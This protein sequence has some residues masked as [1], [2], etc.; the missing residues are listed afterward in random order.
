MGRQEKPISGAVPAVVVLAEFLREQRRQAGG[1][2]YS[3]LAEFSTYDKTTLSR[4]ASGRTTPGE[5]IVLD[6]VRACAAAQGHSPDEALAQARRLWR[7]ARYEER[8]AAD[9]SQ[10][11]P[12][13]EV[14]LIA[15]RAEMSAALRELYEKAGAPS[16]QRM[17]ELAGGYGRLPHSTAHRIV[18]RG[19]LP[20]SVRQLTGFLDAC[21]V[22]GAEQRPWIDAW[23]KAHKDDSTAAA[24]QQLH[25]ARAAEMIVVPGRLPGSVRQL[26]V[27]L[28]ACGVAGAE[29]RPWID[30]WRKA[31]QDSAA[32]APRLP[33]STDAAELYGTT[34]LGK[35]AHAGRAVLRRKPPA[36]QSAQAATSKY[37]A[38]LSHP[39]FLFLAADLLTDSLALAV[40]G[41]NRRQKRSAA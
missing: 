25:P 22:A 27:L 41:I 36:S 24:P 8:R 16:F 2:A 40:E 19:R 35:N 14:E 30:A 18:R 6:F 17:E 31:R 4:A 11:P 37:R 39:L 21:G 13:P 32:A 29:Q 3:Q 1:L 12:A 26:T 38:L 33:H 23:D 5:D 20:G 10:R 7:E 9:G 15:D 28:D 34:A